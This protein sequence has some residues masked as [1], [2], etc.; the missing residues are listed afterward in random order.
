MSSKMGNIPSHGG[1]A[2]DEWMTD[3]RIISRGC[4]LYISKYITCHLYSLRHCPNAWHYTTQPPWENNAVWP[5]I[6]PVAISPLTSRYWL[7]DGMLQFSWLF[8]FGSCG[9]ITKLYT[10]DVIVTSVDGETFPGSTMT[11]DVPM[12]VIP[13]RKRTTISVNAI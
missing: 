6:E 1:E 10:P 8:L 13:T 5:G 9:I 2:G 12:K 3:G 4:R 11:A 7:P